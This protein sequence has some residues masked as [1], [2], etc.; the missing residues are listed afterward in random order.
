ML[1]SA[2]H[3]ASKKF[4][5]N[6][7]AYVQRLIENDMKGVVPEVRG[8][9]IL[10]SLTRRFRPALLQKMRDSLSNA[11]QQL[12]LDNLLEQ[13]IH[14]MEE[15]P[16]ADPL[17]LRVVSYELSV[18]FVNTLKP[19]ALDRLCRKAFRD[20]GLVYPEDGMEEYIAKRLPDCV[21]KSRLRIIR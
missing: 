8:G 2:K 12:V 15:D 21:Q 20:A 17:L 13:I 9:E 3:V 6:L 10:E 7:S 18:Q 16:S 1:D 5:G 4:G 11:D 14:A 19:A